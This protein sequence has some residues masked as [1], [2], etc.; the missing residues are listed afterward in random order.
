MAVAG[1]KAASKMANCEDIG[2]TDA[3]NNKAAD[4]PWVKTP[5]SYVGPNEINDF[6]CKHQHWQK[7]DEVFK[8][9]PEKK[10]SC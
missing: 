2:A 4:I 3:I 9:A 7:L 10:P 8:N 6:A 5:I 1:A